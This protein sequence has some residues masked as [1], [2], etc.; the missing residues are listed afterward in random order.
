MARTTKK[1]SPQRSG[2]GKAAKSAPRVK[3]KVPRKAARKPS[4]AS[5][6]PRGKAKVARRARPSVRASPA[7]EAHMKEI[8]ARVA[9][10]RPG[11][12]PRV[13][14][15]QQD[16]TIIPP[17]APPVP[18]VDQLHQNWGDSREKAVTRNDKPTNW[19][20]QAPKSPSK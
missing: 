19:F 12:A 18:P 13:D 5:V 9:R 4:K 2:K 16:P 10:H 15:A 1:G 17:P 3:A 14:P 6:K 8:R 20:R 7:H 11:E